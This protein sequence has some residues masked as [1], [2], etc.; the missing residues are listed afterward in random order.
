[1]I[2]RCKIESE[3]IIDGSSVMSGN[4]HLIEWNSSLRSLKDGNNMF[5]NCTALTTFNSDLS[6]LIRGDS[7]FWLCSELN[8]FSGDLSSLVTGNYMFHLTKITSFNHYL[9]NLVYADS[10]FYGSTLASFDS[11]LKSLVN[12]LKMFSMCPLQNFSLYSTL[13][14]LVAGPS[15][16]QGTNLD[17][18][19]VNNI[20]NALPDYKN[21]P[22]M[23][24]NQQDDSYSEWDGVSDVCY[25][26]T[27][28][29]GGVEDEIGSTYVSQNTIYALDVAN[30][31]IDFSQ[32]L[33]S[34]LTEEQITEYTTAFE[35]AAN[36][37]GWTIHTN[38]EI[39][40]PY[41]PSLMAVDGTVQRMI[42]VSKFLTDSSH[43]EYIDSAG[44]YWNV[45][46]SEVIIG[47]DVVKWSL[48]PSL[49]DALNEWGL[50]KL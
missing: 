4:N 31:T 21:N 42:Y 16:F 3:K 40:G 23:T 48:F 39:G 20:L 30:I 10:M 7:M 29:A 8:S 13:S 11:D 33:I 38:Y 50:I 41:A 15:M 47:K 26:I 43:G 49:N 12:G 5:A 27:E 34:S 44:N 6:S 2:A 22:V 9:D 45:R 14:S 36:S 17:I 46:T 35:N 19:S 37:K 24:W 25:P 18:E 32:D 1:M 28:I